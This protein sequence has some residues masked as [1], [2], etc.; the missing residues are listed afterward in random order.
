MKAII[1]NSGL[2]NRMGDLT[3]QFHKSMTRLS[4]G[5]TIFHRQLRLLRDAGIRDFII[6]TGPF[7]DQLKGEAADFPDLHFTFVPNDLYAQTNYI[8]SMYLAREYI[9]DDML[10][11]HGDLVFNAALVRELIACPHPS[12]ATVHFTKALPEKDF[13]GRIV[14]GCVHEVGIHIFDE[15]CHAFQPLYKLDKATAR[16]WVEQVAQFVERGEVKCYAENAFN[17]ILPTLQVHAFS[18]EHH[19]IDEIDNLDDYN[20]VAR[21]I[22]PYDAGSAG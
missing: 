11:L 21:E 13:K 15:G 3:K 7:A 6:T 2:G 12:A 18:Y 5:E 8:Y 4:N 19:Y 10:F 9:D 17:V 1:F 16:A 22:E 14:N 20:R